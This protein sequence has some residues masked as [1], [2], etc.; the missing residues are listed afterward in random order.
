MK[1]DSNSSLAHY[2][3]ARHLPQFTSGLFSDAA[4]DWL[5]RNRQSNGLDQYFKKVNGRMYLNTN[6]FQS[7][8]ERHQS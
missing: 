7:W 3:P 8:F 5:I 4:T 2:I 6:G 1:Q